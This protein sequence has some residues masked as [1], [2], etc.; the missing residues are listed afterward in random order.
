[1]VG[2]FKKFN[3]TFHFPPASKFSNVAMCIFN[4]NFGVGVGFYFNYVDKKKYVS[5]LSVGQII[6]QNLDFVYLIS[7]NFLFSYF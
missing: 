4:V 3:L 5:K 2:R 7:K 6:Q 1:V